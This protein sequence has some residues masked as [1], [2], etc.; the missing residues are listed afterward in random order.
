MPASKNP[1]SP[2]RLKEQRRNNHM[3]L[4]ARVLPTALYYSPMPTSETVHH[5]HSEDLFTSAGRFALLPVAYSARL[6][7]QAVN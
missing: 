5:S 3:P 6:H 2:W 7:R 1:F 4:A